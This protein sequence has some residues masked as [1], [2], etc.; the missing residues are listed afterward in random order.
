MILKQ[1]YVPTNSSF[2]ERQRRLPSNIEI[3]IDFY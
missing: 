1:S 2:S 3:S